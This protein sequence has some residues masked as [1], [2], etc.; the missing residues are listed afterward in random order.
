MARA[1]STFFSLVAPSTCPTRTQPVILA[2]SIVSSR[3][4]KI[5][6]RKNHLRPKILKILN[7]K[8]VVPLPPQE[9]SPPL[10]PAAPI[11]CPQSTEENELLSV[12]APSEETHGEVDAADA[13][14]EAEDLED[15]QVSE[16]TIEPKDVSG[17]VSASDIFKFGGVCFLGAIV[18][19]AIL[20]VLF[21]MNY[22]SRTK[23]GNFEV[24]GSEK[25]DLLLNGNGNSEPVTGSNVLRVM[26]QAVRQKKIEEIKLMARKARRIER[27]EKKKK[28][29]E[30]EEEDGDDEDVDYESDDDLSYASSPK[31]GI[32]REIGARLMK[33]QN[34][35]NGN[36]DAHKN[37]HEGNEQLMF[38]KKL[39][40]K[41]P[42]IKATKTPKGFPGTRDH[43]A[44][45]AKDRN[46]EVRREVVSS[47]SDDIHHAQISHEDKPVI[48][49]DDEIRESTPSVPLKERG[50][51][52]AQESEA[53]LNNGKNLERNLETPK[54][55]VKTTNANNSGVWKTSFGLSGVELKQ[56]REPRK[57]NSESFVEE[58]QDT[59]PSFE[60]DVLQNI[61][62]SSRN[63]LARKKTETD[64]WWLNLR[65]VLVILMQGGVNGGTKGI[66]SVKIGS[67]GQDQS[68]DS[69]IV[70]FEDHADANN[71][72]FLLESAFK[73]LGDFSADAV[74]MT[75]QEL[76][77]EILSRGKQ[78]VVV[79][80]R[81]L[82]LFAGQ[83]LGDAEKALCSL[84]EH[85]QNVITS[86]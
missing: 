12:E 21:I 64:T 59:D 43:K 58:K 34:R 67:K 85:D 83:P 79:K 13:T 24:N 35:I 49:Q 22:D 10:E 27:M 62:G 41:Y 76:K 19:Q 72:C 71:F 17:K 4:S 55:G 2:L 65:Y 54:P 40:Y 69:Y 60:K 63:G 45:D 81:Q 15:L 74:P 3:P 80:K 25:R 18:Y 1:H 23:D 57:Q 14:E 26:G 7:P 66:Y 47:V 32:E 31:P 20:S 56:S 16:A 70:A 42:S 33:L 8:P 61:N 86:R 82:Q 46:S 48:E 29:N 9:P 38:K 50:E 36:K 37:A 5:T 53:I 11:P 28:K 51:S 73:E 44:P 77:K 68:E 6:R 39:K 84:I 52:V 30:E 78:V 75:I